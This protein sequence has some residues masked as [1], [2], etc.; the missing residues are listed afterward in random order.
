MRVADITKD[1]LQLGGLA[2]K[3]YIPAAILG[4]LGLGASVVLAVALPDGVEHFYSAYLT[5]FAYFL[6]LALG[7]LFFVLLQHLTGAGWSVVVRRL[8]EG[9]AGSLPLLALLLVPV[10]LGIHELYHWS[11]HDAVVGDH[12]LQWKQP[13]LNTGFFIGRCVFYVVIW[14]LLA[15][16][17]IG[18][19]FNQDRTGEWQLTLRMSRRSAPAMVLFALTITFAAFDLLMSRDPHWY[20][21]IYGVYYF[22]GGAVGFFALLPLFAVLLQRAGRIQHAITREHYHDMGKLVFAFIVF[23][24]YIAFSQ[25]MLIWYANIPEETTWFLKRQTG[26]WAG[27]SL[28][29]VFGHFI[30]PFWLFITRRIKRRPMMLAGGAVWV[31]FVHYVD[32]FWL[33][34]PETGRTGLGLNILHATCLI[35]IGG[36]FVA[37]VAFR[38]RKA[39]LIPVKDPRL[40]E[41]LA[42]ENV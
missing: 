31:L 15:Q 2:A 27:V 7:G 16:Y 12:L 10:L 22:S 11:H 24:A 13:Y 28:F 29:L 36:L 32:L 34:M 42:F 25:Y 33:V 21:T 4:M 38:L 30:V 5:A 39:P 37:A 41:S 20:S 9:V 14:S 17:F 18:R 35:G 26:P 40:E 3:V 23:W 19:S 8:A 1:N 6:S